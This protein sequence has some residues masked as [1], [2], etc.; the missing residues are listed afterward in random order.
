MHYGLE[1]RDPEEVIS[2]VKKRQENLIWPS[3]LVNSKGVDG[4]LWKGDPDAPLVQRIGAVLFASAF[5]LIG[6]VFVGIAWEQRSFGSWLF[7]AALFLLAIRIGY[8]AILKRRRA[9]SHG[10]EDKG[11]PKKSERAD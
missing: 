5:G 7:A 11:H 8:N 9:G 2:E 10:P 1:S 4:L 3:P 6:I